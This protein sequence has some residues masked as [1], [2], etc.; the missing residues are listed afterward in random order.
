MHIIITKFQVNFI[1]YKLL[2][3]SLICLTQYFS[4]QSF[5]HLIFQIIFGKLDNFF[6]YT[7]TGI[8]SG[9]CKQENF[10]HMTKVQ[11]RWVPNLKILLL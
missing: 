10:S 3:I 4:L 8:A 1:K 7:S 6:K 2:Q 5:F 11:F 9:F